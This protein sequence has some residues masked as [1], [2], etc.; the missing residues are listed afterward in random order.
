MALTSAMLISCDKESDS[1][2]KEMEQQQALAMR[3]M[4]PSPRSG[5]FNGEKGHDHR[6]NMG[7]EDMGIRFSSMSELQ[8][9]DIIVTDYDEETEE[10]TAEIYWG[11]EIS[12]ETQEMLRMA[13]VSI[14]YNR[15]GYGTLYNTANHNSGYFPYYRIGDKFSFTKSVWWVCTDVEVR[16]H[17]SKPEY[18]ACSFYKSWT[19]P[20]SSLK[21]IKSK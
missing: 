3:S 5:I 20:F 14:V 11:D 10:F 16:I 19:R 1:L 9:G 7:N 21:Y 4:R 15:A 17:Y 8:E 18:P 13:K 12:K 2:L 6:E